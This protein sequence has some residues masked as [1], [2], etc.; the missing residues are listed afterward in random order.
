MSITQN[1]KTIAR[2]TSRRH[3]GVSAIANDLGIKMHYRLAGRPILEVS[4][5]HD[6]A[7]LIDHLNNH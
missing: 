6:A 5:R 2:R 1:V 3:T 7:L 4:D